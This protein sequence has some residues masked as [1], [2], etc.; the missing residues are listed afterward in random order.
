MY[1]ILTR[2]LRYWQKISTWKSKNFLGNRYQNVPP[3]VTR[4]SQIWNA[5]CDLENGDKVKYLVYPEKSSHGWYFD[6]LKPADMWIHFAMQPFLFPIGLTLERST[7]A[8]K[9][10]VKGQSDLIFWLQGGTDQGS[11][12]AW[13]DDSSWHR[14][15]MCHTPK[16]A[17]SNL[18]MPAM[19][20]KM[21]SRSNIWYVQKSLLMGDILTP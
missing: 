2:L 14:D 17:K 21:G 15:K 1:L 12:H 4:Q 9:S 6:T 7:L 16:V 20:L 13:L 11:L 10:E 19:T 5:W 8:Y 3:K 18:K